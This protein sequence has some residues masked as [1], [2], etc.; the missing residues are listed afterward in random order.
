METS[1]LAPFR[2]ISSAS[3]PGGLSS[4]RVAET[5][6]PIVHRPRRRDAHRPVAQLSGKIP[7]LVCVPALSTSTV[8]A[9]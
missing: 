3:V 7:T 8:V 5:Q 2:V 4:S 1:A 6:R 9:A